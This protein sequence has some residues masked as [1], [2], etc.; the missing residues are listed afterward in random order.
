[1]VGADRE[2]LENFFLME[3]GIEPGTSSVPTG[4]PRANQYPI[5]CLPRQAEP[6]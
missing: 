5:G 1:M 3:P 4:T 2:H 6:V